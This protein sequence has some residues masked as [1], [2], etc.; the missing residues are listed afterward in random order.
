MTIFESLNETTDKAANSAEKYVN[1]TQAY[2]RLKVF[3]QITLSLSLIVKLAL[4]GSLIML[5]IIFTAVSGALAIGNAIGNI[6][7][8]YLIVGLCFL[9]LALVIYYFRKHIERKIISLMS[10]KYFD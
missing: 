10:E 1:T 3:Q 4:I 9:L 8:G 6:P 5:G 2:L 7:V